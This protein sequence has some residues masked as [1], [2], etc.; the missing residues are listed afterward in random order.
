MIGDLFRPFQSF[1]RQRL[2]CDS[3]SEAVIVH[4]IIHVRILQAPSDIFLF[5]FG[6]A[7][8]FNCDVYTV[9]QSLKCARTALPLSGRIGQR[10]D[11]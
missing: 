9:A 4:Q 2:K 11:C 1:S 6:P 3:F 8:G 5:R 10:R 7:S